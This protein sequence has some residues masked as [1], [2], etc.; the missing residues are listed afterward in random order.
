[1]RIY[2]YIFFVIVFLAPSALYAADE[3]QPLQAAFVSGSPLN[4]TQSISL[5][6]PLELKNYWQTIA[7]DRTLFFTATQGNIYAWSLD[8]KTFSTFPTYGKKFNNLIAF[9]ACRKQNSTFIATMPAYG[10]AHVLTFTPAGKQLNPGF[11]FASKPKSYRTI[12][13]ADINN[14][15]N[16]EL[17][18]GERIGGALTIT[19]LD[20]INGK[21]VKTFHVNDWG[22]FDF[23]L[24]RVD[25]GGDGIDEIVIGSG[26]L[27]DPEIRIYRSDGSVINS[28]SAFPNEFKGGINVQS[29]DFDHDGKEEL[30]VG[31]GPGSGQLRILDGYGYEKATNKF[32]PLGIN[33]RGGIVPLIVNGEILA[34]QSSQLIADSTHSKSISINTSNQ[35]LSVLAYGYPFASFPISTGTWDYPTPLGKHTIANKIPRAYSRRWGL[36]MPW[37]MAIVPSGTYGIHELPEWPNGTKE[38]EDHL[39]TR[40]SHGCIRVGVG[41]AKALYD[42]APIGTPITVR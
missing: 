7:I 17:V 18:I 3:Q 30:I 5:L 33:F 20:F 32:F 21:L 6:A 1:M 10:N 13:C 15:Q 19:I 41:A 16:D 11:F 35:T 2:K 29:S 40:R 37:W 26:G 28:F 38:G 27:R 36:Y 42:W 23:N 25:L 14:N 31:S 24:S 9:T 8:E 34:L 4:A 22:P 12:T 39:G